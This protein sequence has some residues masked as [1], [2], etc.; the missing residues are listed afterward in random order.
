M[1]LTPAGQ[2]HYCPPLPQAHCDVNAALSV[3]GTKY[4]SGD[5]EVGV[6]AHLIYASMIAFDDVDHCVAL[7]PG[8]V[9]GGGGRRGREGKTITTAVF[10][11]QLCRVKQLLLVLFFQPGSCTCWILAG[12][13]S[14][15]CGKI[16][17]QIV[18]DDLPAS[19][20]AD[21]AAFPE[22]IVQRGAESPRTAAA[23][24]ISAAVSGSCRSPSD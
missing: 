16:S 6:R 19:L 24:L 15:G 11:D 14:Y 20:W 3:R 23:S 17:H 5:N 18:S 7:C 4:A 12:R 1:P 22:G 10:T 8:F 13:I 9:N 21:F 2:L